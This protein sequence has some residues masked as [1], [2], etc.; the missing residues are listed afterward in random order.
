[1]MALKT[2]LSYARL[3]RNVVAASTSTPP[4]LFRSCSTLSSEQRTFKL[5]QFRGHALRSLLGG[6]LFSLRPYSTPSLADEVM[7]SKD[8]G[9]DK[10]SDSSS[11]SP[12]EGGGEDPQKEPPK[13]PKPLTKWQK[14]GYAAFGV[15]MTGGILLN[16]IVFCEFSFI[17]TLIFSDALDFLFSIKNLGLLMKKL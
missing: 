3:M 8:G 13:G 6:S 12:G 16:T 11:K 5:E 15:L 17:C 4:S 2:S 10:S 9:S 14:I 1:M 7:K